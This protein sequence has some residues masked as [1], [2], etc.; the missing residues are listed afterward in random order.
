MRI[1]EILLEVST[2]FI[3]LLNGVPHDIAGSN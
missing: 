1:E 2:L 3:V